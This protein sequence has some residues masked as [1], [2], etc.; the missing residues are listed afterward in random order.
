MMRIFIRMIRIMLVYKILNIKY[1]ILFLLLF[2]APLTV[3]A[4]TVAPALVE[5]EAEPGET[6]F[7]KIQLLNETDQPLTIYPSLENF[8]PRK[9]SNLPEYLGNDDP[10]AAARWISVPVSE[11]K[12]TSGEIEEMLLQI[13]VPQTAKSG[14]HYVALFWLDQPPQNQ[15]I[16]TASRVPALFLFKIKGDIK[17]EA[18]ILSIEEKSALDDAKEFSLS[19]KNK[20]DV[21]FK[22]GGV[23]EIFN[24]RGKKV[25][26]T[27]I[28]PVGQV[29]LSQGQRQF[30]SL[31]P[32][33][34]QHWGPYS[35]RA[36]LTYGSDSKEIVTPRIKFWLLPQN[37]G[38]RIVGGGI[39]L[40]L[41]WV[42]IRLARRKSKSL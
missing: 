11:V 6:L 40:L 37:L 9:E 13:K 38:G 19:L 39:I 8:K 4:L 42:G 7:Q 41:I 32:E 22:P 26:E 23:W 27:A 5:V 35:V 28:N 15:G 16:G 1:L 17:E 30:N 36:K 10:L 20:G 31:W 29:I 33:A 14:G 34:D 2:F 3:K 21:H 12:L 25:G 18:E 24:W